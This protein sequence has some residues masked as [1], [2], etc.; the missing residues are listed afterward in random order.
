M[1]KSVILGALLVGSALL[2]NQAIS[3]EPGEAISEED[4]ALYQEGINPGEVFAEEEGGGLLRNL[5]V[6]KISPVHHA[7]LRMAR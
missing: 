6:L 3:K 4:W 5:W 7:M 2:F 1:K